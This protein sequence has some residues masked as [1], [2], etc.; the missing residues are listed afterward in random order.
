MDEGVSDGLPS[1]QGTSNAGG[2]ADDDERYDLLQ[3]AATHSQAVK[4]T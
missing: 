1:M 3:L 2:H 4:N